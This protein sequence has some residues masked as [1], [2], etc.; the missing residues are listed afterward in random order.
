MS[1]KEENEQKYFT[2]SELLE[3]GWTKGLIVKFFSEPDARRT[4]P[5][6]RS[7]APVKL[8]SIEKVNAV[9]QTEEYKLARAKVEKRKLAT[10]KAADSKRENS[11]KECE[12]ALERIKIERIPLDRLRSLV[13]NNKQ[14][15]YDFNGIECYAHDADED[16][17][18]RWMVNYIRH[19]MTNYDYCLSVWK[20]S[21]GIKE[22][23]LSFHSRILDK[24]AR[25]YPELSEEC[26]EQKLNTK[27]S[28]FFKSLQDT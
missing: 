2:Q 11:L 20:G 12:N 16:T 22:T 1:K 24:I 10:K 17:V 4:N 23:Y 27:T 15:W 7:A 14:A 21:V 18:R 9:V 28:E 25:I 13:L 6:Y 5:R 26:E 3:Q 8:Y 19:N